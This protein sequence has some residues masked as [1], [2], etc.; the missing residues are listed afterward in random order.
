LIQKA[1]TADGR[2]GKGPSRSLVLWE[3]HESEDSARH[4]ME[5][6]NRWYFLQIGLIWKSWVRAVTFWQEFP[7]QCHMFS[8]DCCT[9]FNTVCFCYRGQLCLFLFF[10]IPSSAFALIRRVAI[11]SGW[12]GA[13]PPHRWLSSSIRN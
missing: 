2:S 1:A 11:L 5:I 13:C 9:Y 8:R 12:A 4:T 7:S 6:W 10:H 3:F